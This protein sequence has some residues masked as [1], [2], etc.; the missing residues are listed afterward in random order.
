MGKCLVSG[1]CVAV[2]CGAPRMVAQTKGESATEK[3]STPAERTTSIGDKTKSM[4]KM[5]GYF[6]IYWDAKTGRLWLEIDKWGTEFLYQTS[7]PAGIGSNDIGLDRGQLGGTRVVRFER[8]GPKVLLVQS[9]LGVRAISNDADERRA[10]RDSFAESALWGFTVVAEDS[11]RALVD[12]TGF[13]L[14]DARAV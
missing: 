5:A 12:A 14:R 1:I 9:N 8:S 7:L 13:F 11:E 2:L 3:T 6:N 10:V 4:E